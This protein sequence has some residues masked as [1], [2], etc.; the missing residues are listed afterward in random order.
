MPHAGKWKM[1]A[2]MNDFYPE[3]TETDLNE[4][5]TA[6]DLYLRKSFISGLHFCYEFK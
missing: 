4:P 2:K 6:I 3:I 5:H 1:E